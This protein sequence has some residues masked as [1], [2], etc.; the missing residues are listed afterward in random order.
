MNLKEQRIYDTCNPKWYM[1]DWDG[2][3]MAIEDDFKD[4][5]TH[6]WFKCHLDHLDD[7]F[8]ASWSSNR[9]EILDMLYADDTEFFSLISLA[10][11]GEE[12]CHTHESEALSD[13]GA[14]DAWENL[15][16]APQD[17]AKISEFWRDILYRYAENDLRE[18]FQEGFNND[19]T[20]E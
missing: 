3:Y 18:L 14:E 15:L 13:W 19:N 6:M 1:P 16:S 20:H 5:A 11:K 8:P 9:E 2:E 7:V 17:E 4:E 12:W 10:M